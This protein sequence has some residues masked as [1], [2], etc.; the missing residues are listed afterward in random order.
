MI[1][2]CCAVHNSRAKTCIGQDRY[3]DRCD[4]A[5]R[6]FAYEIEFVATLASVVKD[7]PV[8]NLAS[9]YSEAQDSIRGSL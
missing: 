5:N 8:E 6:L 7:T 2:D 3:I 9:L 1:P 4:E